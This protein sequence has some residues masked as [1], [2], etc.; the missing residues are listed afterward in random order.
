MNP[1]LGETRFYFAQCVFNTTCHYEAI[2]KYEKIRRGRQNMALLITFSTVIVLVST[3]ICWECDCQTILRILSLI[4]TAFT[5]VTLAFEFYN[6]EDL[7]EIMFYHKQAAEDY[8]TLRDGLMDIIRQIKSGK[9][10]S[11]IESFLKV[12]LRDYSMIGKYSLATTY[13]DYNSAQKKLGLN[14]SNESF[15]WS[16]EEIDRFLPHELRESQFD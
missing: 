6:R 15:T 13:E 8:K 7:T 9:S 4:G 12:C 2:E 1:L 14:G 11:E 3:I 16:K 5:A 10:D